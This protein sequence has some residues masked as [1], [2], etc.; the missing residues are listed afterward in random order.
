MSK[1]E[2]EPD[3]IQRERRLIRQIVSRICEREYSAR[4]SRTATYISLFDREICEWTPEE[5]VLLRALA[6]HR[7]DQRYEKTTEHDRQEDTRDPI[8]FIHLDMTKPVMSDECNV[9]LKQILS[10]N[11]DESNG[12]SSEEAW[13]MAEQRSEEMTAPDSEF[14][15]APELTSNAKTVWEQALDFFTSI[16][17][18]QQ[19]KAIE[20]L[21]EF[22]TAE[23]SHD[24]TLPR[25]CHD[26]S[27]TV[28]GNAREEG[29]SVA[30][31]AISSSIAAGLPIVEDDQETARKRKLIALDECK[32]CERKA[33][34]SFLLAEA[35][36]SSR[37][38]DREAWEKLRE[39]DWSEYFTN[40]LVDYQVPSNYATWSRQLRAARKATG[41]Q[42]YTRRT[43]R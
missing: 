35:M 4:E 33:Y 34:Y 14:V 39:N 13:H 42:K 9:I 1:P 2:F 17:T 26:P 3:T 24:E 16:P 19:E 21:E 25:T 6:Q 11:C 20:Y 30:R 40:E 18:S 22:K 10:R 41:E 36:S 12:L 7:E 43:R 28:Q 32:P 23:Q 15:I 5:C 29:R 31:P 38:E 37:L 8:S 27:T